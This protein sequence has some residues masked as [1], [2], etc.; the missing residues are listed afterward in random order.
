LTL[1]KALFVGLVAANLG[2]ESS[3]KGIV[4]LCSVGDPAV[5]RE[6]S[7]SATT[8]FSS[9]LGFRTSGLLKI[10]LPDDE[11]PSCLEV[12]MCTCIAAISKAIT[13]HVNLEAMSRGLNQEDEFRWI[14]SSKKIASTGL[15]PASP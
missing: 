7:N 2:P 12:A 8:F 11:P 6:I 15:D 4:T 14:D 9:R 5:I 13:S 1:I 10:K 3:S